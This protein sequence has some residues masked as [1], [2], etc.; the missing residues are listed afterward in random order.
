MDDLNIDGGWGATVA[1][2]SAYA[3]KP[4]EVV[5]PDGAQR[6]AVVSDEAFL[7]VG[8]ATTYRR[9]RAYV[10]F[11]IPLL[12]TGQNGTVGSLELV[13]PDVTVGT[14]P[15]SIVDP[16]IGFDIRV[17]GEPRDA[18]RLGIGAQ[19]IF[20][21]GRREDYVT[22]GTARAMVRLLAAGDRG[23]FSYAGQIGLHVRPLD[24]SPE[25][26]GPTGNELL[27]GASAGRAFSVGTDWSAII[28]PEVYGQTP[29]QSSTAGNTGVETLVTTRFERVG[30]GRSFR[31]KIGIGAGLNQHGGAPQWRLVVGAEILGGRNSH[32][33]SQGRQHASSHE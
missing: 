18:L 24:D 25:P 9:F 15:D 30:T 28:G 4:F 26:G 10:N 27:F 16:R 3:H 17:F 8:V 1:I 29:F 19:F 13:A 5:S 23:T 7:D 21:S 11:P 2:T 14:N 12:I 33:A 31:L 6:V 22:D 20:P 32:F